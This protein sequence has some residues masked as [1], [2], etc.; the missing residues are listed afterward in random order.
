MYWQTW[1]VIAVFMLRPCS[2][3]L[4]NRKIRNLWKK[5]KKFCATFS[6]FS[7]L[8]KVLE[9]CVCLGKVSDDLHISCFI[10]VQL[11]DI[12]LLPMS[13]GF[14]CINT[15]CFSPNNYLSLP[16]TKLCKNYL[17]LKRVET[18]HTRLAPN[19]RIWESVHDNLTSNTKL[20]NWAI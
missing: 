14:K 12:M 15:G 17:G 6:I 1:N 19:T 11:L 8:W 10:Q 3:F 20:V 9:F 7:M 18:L 13:T 4:P 16:Q 5:L 2:G